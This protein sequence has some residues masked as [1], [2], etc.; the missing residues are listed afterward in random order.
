MMD[1]IILYCLSMDWREEE[2]RILVRFV[3]EEQVPA[4]VTYAL[5]FAQNVYESGMHVGALWPLIVLVLSHYLTN[6]LRKTKSQASRL[7]SLVGVCTLGHITALISAFTTHTQ[8]LIPLIIFSTVMLITLEMTPQLPIAVHIV[9][10]CVHLA[11]WQGIGS[12]MGLGQAF[13]MWS[14][15]PTCWVIIRL[16]R[17]VLAR[18]QL[19][20]KAVCIETR[21]NEQAKL[22]SLVL[23]IPDGV[24]VVTEDHKIA[25]YNHMFLEQMNLNPSISYTDLYTCVSQ[26]CYDPSFLDAG[27]LT[28]LAEDIQ[29][30]IQSGSS[31]IMNFKPVLVNGRHL[32]WR[33]KL[34][35]WDDKLVCI[36]T[37]RDSTQWVELE[38]K[39]KRESMQKSALLRS[40]SHEL[41]TPANAL[42]NQAIDL[43]ENA[44]SALKPEVEVILSSAKLLMSMIG[45]LLD[46]SQMSY[47]NLKLSKAKFRLRAA[48]EDCFQLIKPQCDAKE[49]SFRLIYDPFLPEEVLS[50]ESRLKQVVLH[51]L[52]NA[53]K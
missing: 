21:R 26:L 20:S 1:H 7:Y 2:L 44:S 48:L 17:F 19:F 39:A 28:S 40:V 4:E 23:A 13:H 43:Y 34:G 15:L 5:L 29:L 36:A 27:K 10:M 25:A 3:M 47:S 11:M 24:V 22:V 41:R 30:Y 32:E 53:V 38:R 31:N 18:K 12:Y 46:F 50:D 37:V 14:L 52:S 49:I 35:Q 51:L 33:G 16:T 9:A 42:I 6:K 45:D 8:G